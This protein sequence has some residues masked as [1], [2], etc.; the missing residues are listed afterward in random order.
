MLTD[1]FA[2][3][4]IYTDALLDKSTLVIVK[5]LFK[6]ASSVVGT[7]SV[8]VAVEMAGIGVGSMALISAPLSCVLICI[9]LIATLFML[10]SNCNF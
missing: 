9:S 10:L 1:S 7:F 3:N 2:F 4:G 8:N 5:T 6:L